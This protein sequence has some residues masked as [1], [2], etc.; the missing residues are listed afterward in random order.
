M[1]LGHENV[2][3]VLPLLLQMLNVSAI[4]FWDRHSMSEICL[5]QTLNNV[6]AIATVHFLRFLTK[7]VTLWVRQGLNHGF[8]SSETCKL[9]WKIRSLRNAQTPCIIGH[10]HF[11]TKSSNLRLTR[12]VLELATWYR[13]ESITN[14]LRLLKNGPMQKIESWASSPP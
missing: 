8:L 1:H 9:R 4:V 7:H 10:D 11:P 14:R 5:S 12:E 2:A 3:W 6:F 13:F